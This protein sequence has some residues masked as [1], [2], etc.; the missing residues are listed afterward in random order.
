VLVLFH[1]LLHAQQLRLQLVAEARQSV[2][3]VVRQL[4]VQY[5]LK[6]RRSHSVGHMTDPFRHTIYTIITA[7]LIVQQAHLTS[8]N[9]KYSS[10]ASCA[11]Q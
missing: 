6:I 2:A 8:A 5:A 1:L 7:Q 10:D 9:I 11:I 3:D 4:L